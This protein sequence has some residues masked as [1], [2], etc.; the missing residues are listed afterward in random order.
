MRTL[1]FALFIILYSNVSNAQGREGE[2]EWI[3]CY[4]EQVY[5]GG[6]LK[7]LGEKALIA[8]IT[9]ADKSFYNPVFSVLHQKSI[10]QSSDYLLSIINKDYLNRKDRVAEPADGKRSLRIALEFYNSNK[11]HLL[12][13]KAYQAW[14]KVPNK[15]ALIEK[16]SAAY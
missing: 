11:L 3:Q 14:L 12:A 4:K 16:A 1:F 9:A 2:K 13:V 6:L 10:N 15:A 8:K 5:Y 7:G